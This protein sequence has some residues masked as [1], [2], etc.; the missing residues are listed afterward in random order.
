MRAGN[1]PARRLTMAKMLVSQPS[2]SSWPE[3][4]DRGVVALDVA[5][6][7]RHA[8]C[9]AGGDDRQRLRVRRGKR[10]LHE[11]RHAA[12]DRR[13]GQRAVEGRGRGD[14]DPVELGLGDHRHRVREAR[15]TGLGGDGR[16]GV[17]VRVG[18][19]G[20]ERVRVPG[21]DAHVVAAHGAQ[22]DEADAEL[23]V[24]RLSGHRATGVATARTASTI[25]ARSSSES[26]GWT[27]IASTSSDRRFVTG[28]SRSAA[29]GMK[30]CR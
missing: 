24:A 17:G 13:V 21:H 30:V 19:G 16:D 23:V 4:Q 14:D 1:G 3:A 6:L 25:V 2:R 26:I 20:Q 5:D 22:A 29:P 28:R 27:G 7:D 10:L 11:D 9:A 12:L 18:D 8:G 15:G